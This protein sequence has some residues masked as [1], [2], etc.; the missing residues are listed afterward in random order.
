MLHSSGENDMEEEREREREGE[1]GER[2]KQELRAVFTTLQ[3]LC[4]L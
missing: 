4:N 2:E 3:F 1:W